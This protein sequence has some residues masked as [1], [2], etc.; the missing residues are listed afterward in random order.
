MDDNLKQIKTE[1]YDRCALN[2]SDFTFELES[3][4]YD[5]C[6]F[7]LNGKHVISRSAKITPKKVGQFVTF[8]K[9]YNDGPIEPFMDDDQI[10]FFVVSVRSDL[11][12]GQ[13][14]F[15]KSIL[16]KKGIISTKTKDGK[17][18]FRVYPNWDIPTSKQ[19][20]STQ[21]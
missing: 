18:A 6:R 8:W 17:R 1:V 11:G 4:E 19:A 21:Q 2:I 16:I 15:P 10:D 14:V 3:R 20:Y 12:F 13:F 7:M 9:R 5:A